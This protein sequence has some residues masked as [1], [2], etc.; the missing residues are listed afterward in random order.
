MLLIFDLDGTLFQAKPV[1]LQADY[2]LMDE[3][4][5]ISPDEQT[6]FKYAGRNLDTFLRCILPESTDFASARERYFE[7][8]QEVMLVQCELFPGIFETVEQLYKEGHEL[9]VCSNSPEVYIKLVLE[10]TG[11]GRFITSFYSAEDYESKA[12]LIREII[13]AREMTY[14]KV[15]PGLPRD[16]LIV[17]RVCGSLPAIKENA[18]THGNIIPA[19][20]AIV[21]GDTHGDV[22]AA[23]ANGLPVIAAAYGYGNKE[24]L[25]AAEYIANTPEEIAD[26]VFRMV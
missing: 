17:Y 4:G 13:L 19:T 6:L 9:I 11:I 8:V 15:I 24:M 26:C 16:P 14:K 21:I 1:V 7:L 25:S 2:A 22:E 5:V 20:P 23:H 10:R 18:I 3:M 12:A